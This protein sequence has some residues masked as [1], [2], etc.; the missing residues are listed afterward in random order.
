MCLLSICTVNRWFFRRFT[1]KKFAVFNSIHRVVHISVLISTYSLILNPLRSLAQTDTALSP[2]LINLEEVEIIGQMGPAILSELPRLVSVVTSNETACAPSHSV[3]D[4]LGYSANIDLRQRGKDGIQSDLSFRGS[5]FDH[6]IILFNG[7]NISDPQT[8]HLSLFLPVES[9]SIRQIEVLN[10]PAARVY[11]ANAFAGAINFITC[12][13]KEN[14]FSVKADAGEHGYFNTHANVNIAS[15][16]FSHNLS[17]FNGS[18]SGYVKNTD[19]RRNS[20]FYQGMVTTKES[21]I[22]LQLGYADRAFGA[23]SYYSPRYPDQYEE[24]QLTFF[25]LGYKTGTT[26]RIHPQVY[27]HRHVDRFELFREDDNW[28]RIEDSL[29]ISNNPEF[30]QYDTIPWYYGHNHHINDIYGAQ[31]TMNMKFRFGMTT[32]GWHL[33][34]ENIIS[35]NI[36]YETGIQIPVYGYEN[37]F[38]TRSDS[39]TNFDLHLEQTV[40]KKF[41]YIAGGILMN[42]N[43]YLPNEVNLFPGID[44]RVFITKAVSIYGSYNYTLGLPTFTDLT[45][46]DPVHEGN[47]RLQPYSQHSYEGGIRYLG[48]NTQFNAACFYNRGKDVID[49]VWFEDE[50]KFRPVNIDTYMGQGVELSGKVSFAD[51]SLL[52]RWLRSIRLNYTFIDMD[53]EVPGNVSKYYNVR[54]KASAMM[55]HE[56][57]RNFIIAENVAYI[58][59]EGNYLT[60]NFTESA[61]ETHSF[62]SYWLVD[63]KISYAWK[64]FAFYAEATNLFNK[65]YIDVGS[66]YQ[67]GRW[68]TAGFKYKISGY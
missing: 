65:Q 16:R 34:S 46:L 41:I 5:S 67:P 8:G 56:F 49:W 17:F 6:N 1:R 21:I 22:D 45:Y 53:K 47:L 15:Q 52:H 12:P 23:N 29:T 51:I 37:T 38:Y 35:T 44:A 57:F 30:T 4:L 50:L 3:I 60:Y 20:I 26:I 62:E 55:Q 39:R 64:G 18:S 40:E 14:S 43:S 54:H 42:W 48:S 66:I 59:R 7:I 13:L 28:Y 31:F 9:E 2:E 25:T 63:L 11:G 27:W 19:Y 58:S 24:N 10:G 32:L 36:G 61:Y 68:I 33:R